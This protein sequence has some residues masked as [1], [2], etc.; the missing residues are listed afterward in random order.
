MKGRLFEYPPKAAFGRVLPK[1]KVFAFGKVTR[2]LRD[3]FATEINKIVWRFKLAPE[4][5]NLPAGPGVT[6]I[7]VFAVDLKSGVKELTE[8]VLYCIDAAIGFP[9]IF[10]VTAS[11]GKGDRVK[12]VAA[13]KRP[14]EADSSKW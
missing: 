2:R 7:Q 8:D 14:S 13:Y 5:I 1:S 6:E 11:G 10:E 12:V 9:I 4:T 3:L